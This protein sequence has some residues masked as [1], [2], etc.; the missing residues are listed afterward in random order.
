MA[1]QQIDSTGMCMIIHQV[2][3][4]VMACSGLI[5]YVYS[6]CGEA[7]QYNIVYSYT[8]HKTFPPLTPYT[9]MYLLAPQSSVCEQ[10][11]CCL[12]QRMYTQSFSKRVHDV[13]FT[14]T[15]R[16]HPPF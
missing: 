13:R 16:D 10:I 5:T 4:I 11:V 15:C 7:N 9:Y 8:P 14:C 1:S 3:H 12:L 2:L 6:L